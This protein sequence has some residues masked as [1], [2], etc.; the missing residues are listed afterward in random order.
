MDSIRFLR[1][2]TEFGHRYQCDN[3]DSFLMSLADFLLTESSSFDAA[4]WMRCI[5]ELQEGGKISGNMMSI[6]KSG[7]NLYVRYA[8]DDPDNPSEPLEIPKEAF[9]ELMVAW[10]KLM[11][12]APKE[13][14]LTHDNGKFELIGKNV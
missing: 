11:E 12:Q 5:N 13:I 14:V 4:Y 9:F 8:Y 3:S 10:E 7:K 6:I 2:D 1:Y